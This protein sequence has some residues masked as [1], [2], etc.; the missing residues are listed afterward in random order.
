M[1]RQKFEI[2]QTVYCHRGGTVYRKAVVANPDIEKNSFEG[3]VGR[4]THYVGVRYINQKGQPEGAEWPITNRSNLILDEES[5]NKMERAKII[6]RLH[7]DVR[8]YNTFEDEFTRYY[9]QAEIICRTLL[10][11]VS[12]AVEHEDVRELAHYLR[13]MFGFLSVYRR[14][15]RDEVKELRQEKLADADEALDE[16]GKMGENRPELAKEAGA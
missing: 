4:K 3:R 16:L 9:E 5:F 15:A 1:A 6:E 11:S 7:S 14:L 13:G 10:N 12:I 2:G 8:A